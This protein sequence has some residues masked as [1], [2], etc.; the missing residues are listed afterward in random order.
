MLERLAALSTS[1]ALTRSFRSPVC[2][3]FSTLSMRCTRS[4]HQDQHSLITRVFANSADSNKSPLRIQIEKAAEKRVCLNGKLSSSE[5]C[6]TAFQGSPEPKRSSAPWLG[7]RLDYTCNDLP[8][9]NSDSACLHQTGML[10]GAD[11]P[12]HSDPAE[13]HAAATTAKQQIT[14]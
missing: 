10:F 4:A 6:Y 1:S 9:S 8:P 14:T 7:I 2:N 12:A 3:S 13:E 5:R 11:R